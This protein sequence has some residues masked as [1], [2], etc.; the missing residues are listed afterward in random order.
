MSTKILSARQARWASELSPFNFRIKYT[1][2][3]DNQRADILSQREQDL[4]NLKNLQDNNQSQV[5]LS[6]QRLHHQINKELADRFL[7]DSIPV[8]ASIQALSAEIELDS[9]TLIKALLQENRNSFQSKRSILPD[10]YQ[11]R[12]RLLLYQDRLCVPSKSLLCTRLI[13]EAHN[14]PSSA[15]PSARKT[16]QLLA[17]HYH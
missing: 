7:T 11:I 12:N 8:V 4:S 6:P 15:H 16:Y 2:G 14:Q 9:L 3:K 17:N 1:P 10:Q 13:Q 5:L